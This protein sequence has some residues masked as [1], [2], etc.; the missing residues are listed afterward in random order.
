MTESQKEQIEV[1]KQTKKVELIGFEPRKYQTNIAYQAWYKLMTHGIC[2][3]SM[4]MRTGKTITSLMTAFILCI[5]NDNV[6]FITKKKAIPSIESD[7]KKLNHQL[8]FTIINYESL[9]KLQK[10][11][12]DLIII[13]EAHSI[14]AYPKPSERYRNISVLF[15]KYTKL[16]LLSGTPSPE[17]YSQLFHQFKLSSFSPFADYTSFYSFAKEFVNVKQQRV[18]NNTMINNYDDCNWHKLMP[19]LDKYFIRYT[20]NDAGFEQTINEELFKVTMKPNTYKMIE[21][22]KKDL[23]IKGKHHNVL[24][25]TKVKLLN[26]L[27]QLYSG[28]IIFECGKSMVIDHSKANFIRDTFVDEKIAIFY[29]YKAECD[30]LKATF[31]NHTDNPEEFNASDDFVFLG[32]LQSVKEGVNLSTAD[33]LIFYN[34]DFSSVTYQQARERASHKNR[35]KDNNVFFIFADG[36]IEQDIYKVLQTKQDYTTKHYESYEREQISKPNN[37]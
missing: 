37:E 30:L 19:I 25:D 8:N 23:I 7:L 35:V 29:K 13:D 6:L 24:A 16:L 28:T 10:K 5:K 3:L 4:Q 20:Q 34:I 17:S 2:Y 1:I 11:S 33:A 26:K 14:G 27:H 12:W 22:L 15:G 36:G 21:Q 31:P 9:H 32:Q 18:N